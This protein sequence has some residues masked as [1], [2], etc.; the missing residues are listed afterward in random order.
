MDLRWSKHPLDHP[1]AKHS[2]HFHRR[3]GFLAQL[4]RRRQKTTRGFLATKAPQPSRS[5]GIITL[6]EI[7]IVKSIF[8]IIDCRGAALG[9][10]RCWARLHRVDRR[11]Q[12]VSILAH[13]W[14][15]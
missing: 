1:F 10:A 13:S 9:G 6:I 15:I 14:R 4:F 11:E 2:L 3:M 5:P 12:R 7:L 8:G